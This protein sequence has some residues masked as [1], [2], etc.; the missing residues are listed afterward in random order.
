MPTYTSVTVTGKAI[1]TV[2]VTNVTYSA[3]GGAPGTASFLAPTGTVYWNFA[4]APK[5]GNNTVVVQATDASGN[6]GA[7]VTNTFFVGMPSALTIHT[8]AAANL[9]GAVTVYGTPTNGANLIIDKRYKLTVMPATDCIFSNVIITVDGVA[10]STNIQKL[11][12]TMKTN[13]EIWVN[14]PS[15]YFLAGAGTYNGLF[16]NTND[17]RSNSDAGFI[18]VSVKVPST[19]LPSWSA[20]VFLKG[21][22]AGGGGGIDLNGHGTLKKMMALKRSGDPDLSMYIDLDLE[23]QKVS[24]QITTTNGTWYSAVDADQA[25]WT[26]NNLATDYAGLYTMVV[27]GATS[28]ASEP[29]GDGYGMVSINTNTGL[30]IASGIFG[31]GQAW[32]QKV[33]LSK[34][35]RWPFFAWMNKNTSDGIM[36]GDLLVGCS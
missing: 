36:K 27:T 21:E 13:L 3:N 31:D 7:P 9:V 16:Y 26:T 33:T 2:A 14:C 5:A 28:S 25:L 29:G 35:G 32:K 12:F 24:G 8:N 30:I 20:K 11:T 19:K 22:A 23:H 34:D 6:L 18:T 15:N 10:I 4:F 17:V 1:D